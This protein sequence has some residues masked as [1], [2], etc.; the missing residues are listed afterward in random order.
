MQAM[1]A[2]GNECE[3]MLFCGLYKAVLGEECDPGKFEADDFYAFKFTERALH[4]ESEELRNLAAHLQAQRHACLETITLR[5]P[6]NLSRTWRLS[7]LSHAGEPLSPVSPAATTNVAANEA[8]Q[9]RRGKM[10]RFM[11]QEILGLATLQRL[12][13]KQFGRTLDVVQFA[14]SDSYGRQVLGEA[15]ESNNPDL[16]AAAKCFLDAQGRPHRHRRNT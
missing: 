4:T 3:Q 9:E 8:M 16:M 13:R 15:M 10:E 12:Y 14:T 1:S 2:A 5:P 11:P 7:V 6:E